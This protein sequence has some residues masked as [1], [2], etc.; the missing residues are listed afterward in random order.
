MRPLK[1]I[2]IEQRAILSLAEGRRLIKAGKI[3]IN[4][5]TCQSLETFIENDDEVKVGK[6]LIRRMMKSQQG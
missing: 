5:K 6:R 1:T 3:Q 2:L 4:G